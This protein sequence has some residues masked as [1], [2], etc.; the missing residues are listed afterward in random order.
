MATQ[1]NFLRKDQ[2]VTCAQRPRPA[3]V[4]HS[5]Q[6]AT[7]AL[8]PYVLRA[9][10]N[11]DVYFYAKRV[12]NSR[13][14]RE[15]DPRAR[16]TCWSAIGA[17]CAIVILLTGMLAPSVGG[18]LAGYQLQALRQEEQLLLDER[19]NL[20]VEEAALVSPERMDRLAGAH[21]LGKPGPGQL[22]HLNPNGDGSLALNLKK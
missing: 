8:D 9:L 18:I 1:P 15:A 13:I 10:P 11:D 20:E 14:V 3:Q 6:A 21:K 19:K 16:G 12:D 2:A 17:G 22:I 4:T 7:A 5:F